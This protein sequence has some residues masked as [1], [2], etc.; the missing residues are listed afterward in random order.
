MSEESAA[1]L[2]GREEQPQAENPSAQDPPAGSQPES[3]SSASPTASCDDQPDVWSPS[4]LGQE[5]TRLT[6]CVERTFGIERIRPLQAKAICAAI[7][8][9]DVLLVLPT[10]GGKSLCYQAPTLIRDGLTAVISPLISL[11]KDQVDGLLSCGVPC[12]MLTSAQTPAERREVERALTARELKL[13]FVAPERLMLGGFFDWLLSCGLRSVAVD[14]AHCISH[15]GHD[16][17]PEYRQLGELRMRAPELAVQAFTATASAEVREDIARELRLR[18]PIILVGDC[19]RPNLTYRVQQR[20]TAREQVLSV[21]ERHPGQAGIVYALSR[22]EVESMAQALADKGLRSAPYHAGLS[23]ERRRVTQDRFQAEEIDVVVATVAFGMGIDRTDV[24][25]V[26]HTHLPKG[27]EQYSQE[28][29]RA[30]RD[31]LP[32]ECVLLFAAGDYHSWKSM[33][34]R[35]SQEAIES[36][37][38]PITCETTLEASLTRLGRMLQFAT[39]GVCR[40]RQLVENFGQAWNRPADLPQGTQGCG[41]CDVC[42]GELETV[43]ESQVIAQ[44]ILS[45]VVRCDQRYGAAHITEVL[46]GSKSQRLLRT[47]HEQLSTY[48]LLSTHSLSD[49]RSFIDQLIGFGHLGVAEGEFPTLHLTQQGL[50]VMRGEA[51]VELYRVPGAKKDRAGRRASATQSAAKSEL[52]S[53]ADR[54]LFEHL[55][56]VRREMAKERG[57]PPYIVFGDR[58]LAHMASLRPHSTEEFRQVRGVGEKKA[59]DL[60]PTFLEAIRNFEATN[61][62]A[63]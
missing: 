44:K 11:M 27:M 9:R 24:R 61:S 39:A 20:R 4:Y 49:V 28:T 36:G 6:E 5:W 41:A 52:N 34:E 50:E 43:A 55:R 60:G 45:C 1:S 13:I 18:D 14:E 10:G 37:E 19:D 21:V 59:D 7:E 56:G 2:S 30:G 57:V 8:E 22:R 3:G 54:E 12:G 35:S 63:S 58:A 23:A 42:L 53:D 17:R 26:I 16:F 15:W 32:A 48:G 31:G 25:F 38:N 51:Q 40:H 62:A 33:L 29:G 47:G 46:R